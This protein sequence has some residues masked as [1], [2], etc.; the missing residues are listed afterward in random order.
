MHIYVCFIEFTN[1]REILCIG[2][3][4]DSR[5]APKACLR[6]QVFAY[7]RPTPA[8]GRRCSDPFFSN[9]K[10]YPHVNES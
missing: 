5:I 6:Y 3:D 1:A 8:P 2:R 7:K 4:S 10:Q 9:Y